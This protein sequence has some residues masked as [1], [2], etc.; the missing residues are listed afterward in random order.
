MAEPV[1]ICFSVGPFPENGYWLSLAQDF[2][3]LCFFWVFYQNLVFCSSFS[4]FFSGALALGRPIQKHMVTGP[5]MHYG[6]FAVCLACP[7]PEKKKKQE[8]KQKN[9]RLL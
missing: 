6:L 2:V 1:A 7:G 4:V 3:F 5:A 8:Q 9:T